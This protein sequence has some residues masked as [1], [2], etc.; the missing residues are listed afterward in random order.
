MGNREALLEAAIVCLRERG[1]G[2]TTARDVTSA[3]R[4]SLGAI[5]Y[6]FGSM[7]GLLDEA[8]AECSRRWTCGFQRSM[9]AHTGDPHTGLLG[10]VDRLYECFESERTLMVGFV[11]AFAHAQRSEST[12]QR[13][14]ALYDEMRAGL[15]TALGALPGGDQPDHDT[16]ASVLMAIVDGL[17]VQWLLNPTRR[18]DPATLRNIVAG[19]LS[20]GEVSPGRLP[21]TRKTQRG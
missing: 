17:M 13:L 11:E 20:P 12:R 18:P 3:A 7:Q 9:A 1:Y 14:A 5:R 10:E 21:A 16:R 4:V 8:V 2:A 6:H 19:L 15:A